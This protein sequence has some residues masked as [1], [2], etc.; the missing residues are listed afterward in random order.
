MSHHQQ[1]PAWRILSVPPGTYNANYLTKLLKCYKYSMA[2][3]RGIIEMGIF[4]NMIVNN[5]KC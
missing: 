5:K 4:V 2:E 3:H 1:V